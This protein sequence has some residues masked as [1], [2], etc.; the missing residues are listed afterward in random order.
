MM[1]IF[2]W[3]PAP[4]QNAS[5]EIDS[6]EV[7]LASEERREW[8]RTMVA[9]FFLLGVSFFLEVYLDT[10]SFVEPAIARYTW[11]FVP[12]AIHLALEMLILA[13]LTFLLAQSVFRTFFERRLARYTKKAVFSLRDYT[14]GLVKSEF[15]ART[16]DIQ[17]LRQFD[18]KSLREA[19]VNMLRAAFGRRG[20]T[21]VPAP[22]T[23][24]L[25]TLDQMRGQLEIWRKDMVVDLTCC[26]Y[27][28]GRPLY[29][30]TETITWDYVN[31]SSEKTEVIPQ[32]IGEVSHPVAGIAPEEVYRVTKISVD[33]KDYT[34]ELRLKCELKNDEL[35]FSGAVDIPVPDTTQAKSDPRFT[36]GSSRIQRDS[37]PYTLTFFRPVF[38]FKLI[39]R[40]PR[41]VLPRTF[42]FG[43]GG[44]TE[45]TDPLKPEIESETLHSWS[46]DGWMLPNH[47]MVLILSKTDPK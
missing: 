3:R 46:F 39:L 9:S 24:F 16:S 27:G 8:S 15:L 41:T 18:D 5:S 21:S 35:Y 10:H 45:N 33:G 29:R 25:D 23:S 44:S 32:R 7:E 30:M 2:T 47:G 20:E 1:N 43:I 26:E 36:L 12:H 14:D 38:H 17:F 31:Y 37:E 28:E 42:L 19:E 13:S 34:S 11:S 40:H 22:V 4:R 6:A